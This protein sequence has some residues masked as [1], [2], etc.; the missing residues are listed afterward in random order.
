MK[1]SAQWEITCVKPMFQSLILLLMALDL[2]AAS[3]KQKVILDCDLGGDI[4]DA[5]AMALV[6]TSPEFEVLGITLDHGL[7]EKRAQVACQLLYQTGMGHIPV[8][9]G[10]RTPNVIG[11]DKELGPHSPQFHW[12][13]GFSKLKP[14]KTSAAD[15]IIETLHKHPHEVI[16]FGVGPVPNL[17]DVIEKDPEAL[18]LAKHV[19]S[20][21]GSFFMGYS[22]GPV[23]SAEWNVYADI[24]SAKR[25]ASSGASITYAGLDITTF[26]TLEEKLRLKLLMRQ[27]PLTNALCGLYALWGNE[28]PVLYDAVAV[29]MALWP[30]LFTTRAAHVRVVDGGFTIVDESKPPNCEIG[31]SINKEEF[32]KRLVGRLLEQNL[33]RAEAE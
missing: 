9:I 1:K 3:S 22:G 26:V 13:E 24:V 31:V 30:D 32:L 8:A 7:T 33:G 11:K 23:P 5:F 17:A 25:F 12:A 18:K 16:L 15:F 6:L 29:G 10:R 28:T 21:F 2:S 19:Y 4:D 27:S 14:I 20:M